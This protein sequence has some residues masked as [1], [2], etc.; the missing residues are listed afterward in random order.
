MGCIEK[1]VKPKCTFKENAPQFILQLAI[2][3]KENW[4]L[5][6]Q[7]ILQEN[8]HPSYQNFGKHSLIQNEFVIKT[9]ILSNMFSR[10]PNL[11]IYDFFSKIFSCFL[12]KQDRIFLLRLKMLLSKTVSQKHFEI[13]LKRKHDIICKKYIIDS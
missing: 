9:I 12:L 3:L 8:F 13:L 5:E 7:E 11:R 6:P 10:I 2:L 1:V 4:K